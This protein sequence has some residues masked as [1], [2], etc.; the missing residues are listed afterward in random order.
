M[1]N[2]IKKL[3]TVDDSNL[4]ADSEGPAEAIRPAPKSTLHGD[5]F[6]TFQPNKNL[7]ISTDFYPTVYD[8]VF[9]VF[10]TLYLTCIY[11]TNFFGGEK[12]SALPSFY[13]LFFHQ[14][15]CSDMYRNKV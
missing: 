10:V 1:A 8:F 15:I 2:L 5:P 6:F 14:P 12:F 9:T 7:D 4:Q 3:E 13:Q 11:L